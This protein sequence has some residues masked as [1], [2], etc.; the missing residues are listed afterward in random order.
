M[1]MA[2]QVAA[3]GRIAHVGPTLAKVLPTNGGAGAGFFDVFS[4][5]RPKNIHDMSALRGV[6]GTTIKL[7]RCED[8]ATSFRGIAVG[9]PCGGALI[10]LSFG[11][12]A[13]GAA[14]DSSLSAA[15]FAPTD[16]TVELLYAVE[17][18]RAV[19]A[20]LR[21]YNLRLHGEKSQAEAQAF[22]DTLT[23]LGN[24][25]AL[26]AALTALAESDR[27]F[28]LLQIDLDFFKAINDTFGHAAGDAV[29]R[30]VAGALTRLRKDGDVAVRQGGDEF[31]L[32]LRDRCDSADVMR[33]ADRLL[34]CIAE[35]IEFEG[36]RCKVEAS[37]GIALSTRYADRDTT[38]MLRDAD[39]ALYQAKDAGRGRA[40][41]W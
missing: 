8:P 20:E 14:G 30:H 11:L 7:R 3:T 40:V 17:A 9:M 15:D 12:G 24:R 13:V 33:F 34:A 18:N 22:T 1:P 32:L 38:Q 28:A 35:P 29:L 23:G 27:D 41:F 21:S 39:A 10:N 2:V 5:V 16:L 31:M 36:D 19:H 4:F 6:Y 25:R 37:I 26:D